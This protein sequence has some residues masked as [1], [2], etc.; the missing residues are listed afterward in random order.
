MPTDDPL[1]TVSTPPENVETEGGDGQVSLTWDSPSDDGGAPVTSYTVIVYREGVAQPP[2]TGLAGPN[3][4]ITGL[5]NGFSYQFKVIA[6][7][8][9]GSSNSSNITSGDTPIA[10]PSAPQ[11][12]GASEGDGQVEV[13]WIT[14]ASD[15]GT[16]ITSYTVLPYRNGVAQTPVTG[17]AGPSVIITG[18]DNGAA[19][20]FTVTAT[21]LLGTSP[22][23]SITDA[24]IP[25]AD[26]ATPTPTPT[27]TPAPPVPAP[28]PTPP[29]PV[30]PIPLAG[31]ASL[32]ASWAP[33]T[34]AGVTG[35]T[36]YAHPGSATC[37][38]SS[39]NAT[40][41]VLGGVA[42]QAYTFTVVAHSAG[43]DSVPSPPSPPITPA[44]PPVPETAPIAAPVTLTTTDG[45]LTAVSPAQP[46]TVVGTGFAAH[47]TAMVV[48]YSDPIVLASVI[49]DGLG[50]FQVQVTV[51]PKL[52]VGIHNFVA[53]GVDTTGTAHLMRLPVTVTSADT[54][55]AATAP[56]NVVLTPGTTTLGV[57]FSRPTPRVGTGID[58]YQVSLDA[59]KTWR[60]CRVTGTTRLI[61]TVTGLRSGSRYPVQVRAHTTGGNGI[62]S[63]TFKVTLKE[64]WYRDPVTAAG[65]T[66]EARIPKHPR[67]YHG[68]LRTTTSSYRAHDGAI[69]V[70]ASWAKGHHLGAK[71]AVTLGGRGMFG[72]DSATIT[73]TG[74]AQ[75]KTLAASLAGNKAL[76]CE[77]YTDYGGPS[78][79]HH[80]DLGR[81]RAQ[82]A[83]A[84]LKH[85]GVTA[86]MRTLS[87]GGARPVTVGGDPADRTANRRIV[88]YI[89][90]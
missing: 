33:S 41:C 62:A 87:Y 79:I 84:A 7:N 55:N 11:F 34:A 42:G 51:P 43:G 19:Y 12:P 56:E 6:I 81:R 15:G 46:V 30:D 90:E 32:T 77:G 74:S 14:P 65:R 17:L 25:I 21:N 72:F 23:S 61:G 57:A 4:V 80:D 24:V 52:E 60:L 71:Q 38:T 29:A 64:V 45:Q 47:S 9:A 37:S 78:R 36:A 39:V 22:G 50:N 76:T 20:T 89:N 59:G 86:R 63:A 54:A 31:V 83:C 66:T 75:L 88:I 16:P 3:A 40:S 10:V 82:T 85:F 48:M 13:H 53:L 26:I 27:P 67:A 44:S 68:P 73:S 18:L 49:T 58:G 35:Y 8:S 28:A 70:P 69:A 2:I 1:I 5:D